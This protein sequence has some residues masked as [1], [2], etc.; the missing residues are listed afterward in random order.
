MAQGDAKLFRDFALKSNQGDYA[1]SDTYSLA[2]LSDQYSTID[3]DA[4]N[5]VLASFTVV[6]G[7]NIPAA[8]NLT[9]YA[10]TRSGTT[11]TFDATDP[12]TF[13]KNAS[14]PI[15]AKSLLVYNNT[16]A[17]DDA[18]QVFDLT[19]DGS[20]ALDLVNNDLVFSF[21]ASGITTATTS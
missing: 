3:I 19:S 8:T 20:T 14:N 21:G 6:S 9:G 12:A 15:T 7:G 5:P 18:Y 11:I 16:S 17:S 10:I 2:F 4:T 13:S 1:D